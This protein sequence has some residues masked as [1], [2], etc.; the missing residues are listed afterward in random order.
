MYTY[1]YLY[2]YIN[3]F[4]IILFYFIIKKKICTSRGLGQI[5]VISFFLPY[6]GDIINSQDI[7]IKLILLYWF[8]L[9]FIISSLLLALD[10][11]RL[12]FFSF[13]FTCAALPSL[14]SIERAKPLMPIS[15]CSP[16]LSLFA[17]PPGRPLCLINAPAQIHLSLSSTLV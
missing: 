8:C 1:I 12:L 15:F 2:L 13:L 14:A 4:I 9:Q 3:I 11:P 7:I 5:N 17:P 6:P 16:A 10:T